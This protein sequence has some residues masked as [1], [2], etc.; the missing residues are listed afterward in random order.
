[1]L[2]LCCLLVSTSFL[3]SRKSG[4]R[5]A[6]KRQQ[7]SALSPLRRDSKSS[8]EVLRLRIGRVQSV[9]F[10][11]LPLWITLMRWSSKPTLSRA[12]NGDTGALRMASSR[13]YILPSQYKR[14]GRPR[15]LP[16][17][18]PICPFDPWLIAECCLNKACVLF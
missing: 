1:M 15:N 13:G 12:E 18:F 17:F 8:F 3:I 10:P 6:T 11:S 4:D 2:P 7:V 5:V 16:H 9:E 14:A